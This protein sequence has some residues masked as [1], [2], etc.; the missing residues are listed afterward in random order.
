MTQS[1]FRNVYPSSPGWVIYVKLKGK[2]IYGGLY[3]S[4]VI[5]AVFANDLLKQ[6]TDALLNEIPPH[7][8]QVARQVP[9]RRGKHATKAEKRGFEAHAAKVDRLYLEWLL[10]QQAEHYGR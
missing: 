10:Q 4:D 7:I 2:R 8:E 1:F 9:A 3:Y 5:A 6:R